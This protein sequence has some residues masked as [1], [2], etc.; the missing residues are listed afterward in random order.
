MSFPGHAQ[1][2]CRG[3]MEMIASILEVCL[4]GTKKTHI[5][6]RA[7]VSN[8]PLNSYLQLLIESGMLEKSNVYRTTVK[9]RI[10]LEHF[11]GILILLGKA[12]V[13]N[14]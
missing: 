11:K 14:I 1:R 5:M 12:E 8:E 9:G 3:T 2:R 4:E 13:E 7:N 6:Y 10:Y